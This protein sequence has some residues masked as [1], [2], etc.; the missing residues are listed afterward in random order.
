MPDNQFTF[1][2]FTPCYNSSKFLYR[3]FNSLNNLTYR[4]FEWIVINDASTDNTSELIRE[5]IKTADFEIQ[6]FDLTENQMLTK[7]YNI[8]IKNARGTYF[9]PAGHD[10]EFLPQTLEIF[11]SY[12]EKYGTPDYS[13]ISCLCENQFGNIVGDHFPKS[14]YLS[15]YFEVVFKNKIKGEK[16]GFT[17]TEVMREFILP[18]NIDVYISEGLMWVGIGSKYKTIYINEALRVYYVDQ[19]NHQGLSSVNCRIKYPVGIR[20]SEMMM[21]NKYLHYIHGNMK[22]KVACYINYLRMSINTRISLLKIFN[23]L[24]GNQQKFIAFCLLPVGLFFS[25]LDK[26]QNRC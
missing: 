10:D 7:N 4:N 16:W 1:T 17:R 22:T 26:I 23:D 21:I 11:L 5:F 24:D 18:E 13:G 15:D 19:I 6:F 25:L 3:V 20:Y 8:A 9:L 12:W 14:P 2:I